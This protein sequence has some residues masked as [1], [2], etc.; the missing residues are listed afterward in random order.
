MVDSLNNASKNLDNKL[1][2]TIQHYK[3]STATW[4]AFYIRYHEPIEALK[5]T[6]EQC[7]L[8]P[9]SWLTM[10]LRALYWLITFFITVPYRQYKYNHSTTQSTD[11]TVREQF[12]Y[13]GVSYIIR[14]CTTEQYRIL[15]AIHHGIEDILYKPV[16]IKFDHNI[17]RGHWYVRL[18][19][20]YY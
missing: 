20:Y 12:L 4:S 2:D 15:L 13:E 8:H 11:L 1:T 17:I 16:A 10:L 5:Y 7:I 9:I 3:Q 6:L 14:H 19:Y 18:Y